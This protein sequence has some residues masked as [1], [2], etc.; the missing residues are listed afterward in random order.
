MSRKNMRGLFLKFILTAS[1]FLYVFAWG[2]KY[3]GTEDF[4]FVLRWW[5]VLL[6]IGIAV[7]PL[8]IVLFRR[9]HDGGWL[10]SKTIGLALAGWLLW[11][12]S[13]CKIMKFTR[14]N[15]ILAVVLC[16]LGCFVFF[17]FYAKRNKKKARLAELYSPSRLCSMFSVET[18]FFTVFVIWCYMKGCNPAAYGTERFMDYSFMMT[19]SKTEYMPPKDVWLSGYTI[20][21]Y[22]VGQY[23]MTYLN[24]L[25]GTPVTHGYNI[26][27]MT[28]AAL[29]TVLPYSIGYNLMRMFLRDRA[30]RVW[31]PEEI[32]NMRKIGSISDEEDEPVFRPLIAGLISSLAVGVAGTM[33]YP[34]Y[35]YIYPR[36]Q[37]LRGET[38]VYRYYFADT[39]R[40]I[41]Y[42]PDRADKT[43]HEFPIYSFTIGDLHAHVINM[44]FV[45]TVVALLLA[46]I[47]RR[48]EKH[49]LVRLYDAT[50]VR[51]P[52]LREVFAPELVLC[53]FFVGI[54][55]TT[56]YWDFPIYFVVCGAIILFSNL[57][58][59]RFKKESLLLTAYQAAMFLILGTVV[60]LPFSLT[61]RKISSQIGLCTGVHHT[62]LFQLAIIWGLPVFCVI[63]FLLFRIGEYYRKRKTGQQIALPK[64]LETKAVP[65]TEKDPGVRREPGRFMSK[66]EVADLFVITIGLCA[67]GLVLLPEIIYVKDIYGGAYV[68][69]NTMFKLTY[70]AFI[71]FGLCMGYILTRFLS[72]PNSRRMKVCGVVAT[73][74]FC[75]TVGY[76]NEAYDTWFARAYKTLDA[77]DF[78]RNEVS[79]ED[80]EMIDYIN[81]EIDKQAVI[82]EMPGLSYTYFNR[83][84]SFT[85][86]P[87]VIGWQVHEWLWQSTSGNG[88]FPEIVQTREA[89]ALEL[90]T[91][92]DRARIRELVEKYDIEYVY[93]GRCERVDGLH[94]YADD[95]DNTIYMDGN[96]YKRIDLNTDIWL[97]LGEVV[98]S[99]TK[100]NSSNEIYY[101]I[102]VNRD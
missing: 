36:L 95:T 32:Q 52:I 50:P 42:V 5:F 77:S 41:G 7:Q 6:L 66:I 98:K 46:W 101:L 70:Q 61:F 2:L 100:E 69:A 31:T 63:S 15:S 14:F 82:L 23:F 48:R 94:Q 72:M 25:T 64:E 84:S 76:F 24:K 30:E 71:L 79:K 45:L 13:S 88:D 59:Y 68:R 75:M 39:T 73:V 47:W 99:V 86:M 22:Y 44:V 62:P 33:H 35:K 53:A 34:I 28:I 18:M 1:V 16:F 58:I 96:R 3:L 26:A 85:G 55:R 40:Y 74:C 4:S 37:R 8:T 12:L 10:F 78:I 91:S 11:F 83:I 87:T 49:N 102:K 80:A 93:I 51:E 60:A 17:S 97:E 90:Y 29:G 81:E 67:A 89:E 9:F 57:V 92:T 38:D 65:A 19:M 56:N 43:I 27:M 54:F 20:N 21:Y